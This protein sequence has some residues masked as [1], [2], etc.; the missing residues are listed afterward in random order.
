MNSEPNLRTRVLARRRLIELGDLIYFPHMTDAIVW[1]CGN[2]VDLPFRKKYMTVDQISAQ[3]KSFEASKR[4][5]GHWEI[6]GKRI[7]IELKEVYST[8]FE[9]QYGT[10]YIVT[11]VDADNRKFTYKGA[12]PPPTSKDEFKKLTGTIKHGTYRDEPQ[13]LMQRIK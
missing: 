12:N 4:K 1:E 6:E 10:C 2:I 9:T 11:M 7:S 8:G 5:S 13:T 3:L